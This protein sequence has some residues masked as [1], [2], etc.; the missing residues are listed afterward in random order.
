[1]QSSSERCVICTVYVGLLKMNISSNHD[2]HILSSADVTRKLL[3]KVLF[4]QSFLAVLVTFICK[5]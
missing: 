1:M 4:P 2:I 5:V 3:G